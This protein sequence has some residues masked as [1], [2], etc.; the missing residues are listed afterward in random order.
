MKPKTLLILVAMLATGMSGI[1]T[2]TAAQT[3]RTS[4]VYLTAADFQNSRLSFEGSCRSK[5]HKLSVHDFLHKPYIDVK[6]E[7]EKHRY[8]KADLFGFRA[9]DRHDYRFAS[10]LEYQILEAKELY[11]YALDTQVS[12]GRTSRTVREYYFSVGDNG[13]IQMLTLENLKRAFP[14]NHRFHVWLDTTFGAG[15]NLAEYDEG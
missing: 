9:C 2:R 3:S 11:I 14:E 4:G 6:H 8:A 10:N 7:S 13:Q 15:E 12:Q 1:D 5:D